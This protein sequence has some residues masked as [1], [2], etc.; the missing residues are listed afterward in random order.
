MF[1]AGA[2]GPTA[3]QGTRV[4]NYQTQ[5]LDSQQVQ[6]C[7]A[8]PRITS[9]SPSVVLPG[10]LLTLFGSNFAAGQNVTFAGKITP[11][12]CDTELRASCSASLL[13][14][15]LSF[16]N[17]ALRLYADNKETHACKSYYSIPGFL[18]VKHPQIAAV[19]LLVWSET[20]TNIGRV[21]SWQTDPFFTIC[22]A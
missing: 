14:L 16:A 5:L 8:A 15:I 1:C 20:Q 21:H 12:C 2:S 19:S 13:I 22:R 10:S 18:F 7:F 9:V 4:V 6:D 17:T 11:S 3:S